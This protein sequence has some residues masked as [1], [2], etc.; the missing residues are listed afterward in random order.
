MESIK[1]ILDKEQTIIKCSKL[2]YIEDIC[3]Q[4]TRKINIKDNDIIYLY[5]GK[6]MNPKITLNKQIQKEDL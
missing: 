4:F 6:K 2:D 1:F 5:K 3:R